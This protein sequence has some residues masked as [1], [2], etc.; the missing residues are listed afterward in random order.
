[1]ERTQLIK[2]IHTLAYRDLGLDEEAY[3]SIVDSITNMRSVKDL[4]GEQ[5]NLVLAYLERL[6]DGRLRSIPQSGNL[7]GRPPT[8]T[9]LYR[10][11]RIIARLMFILKWNWK[12]TAKFCDRVVGKKDTRKCDA[13][14]LVKVIAG[15]IQIIETDIRAGKITMTDKALQEFR[16]HTQ[17]NVRQAERQSKPVTRMSPFDFAQGDAQSNPPEAA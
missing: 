8:E 6:H 4:G 10:Q 14:E 5:L 3:R 13:R 17:P 9:G 16:K 1:M 11:H 15:M 7:P 2:R 12:S